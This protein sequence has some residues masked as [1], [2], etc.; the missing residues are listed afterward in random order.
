MRVGGASL[1]WRR[2][3]GEGRRGGGG[4]SYGLHRGSIR[5]HQPAWG[6]EGQGEESASGGLFVCLEQNK[7]NREGLGLWWVLVVFAR[8]T[9]VGGW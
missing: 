2:R 1:G 9:V 4:D 8:Q 7:Q 3:S 5:C 6:R